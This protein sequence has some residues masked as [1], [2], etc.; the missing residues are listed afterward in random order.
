VALQAAQASGDG[1]RAAFLT[2]D[3]TLYLWQLTPLALMGRLVV[4]GP[5]RL[6]RWSA[7][8]PVTFDD[9]GELLVIASLDGHVRGWTTAPVAQVL[10]VV[11]TPPG[12][13]RETRP[14]TLRV[15]STLG[16]NLMEWW[17]VSPVQDVALAHGLP[18]LATATG[19]WLH[20]WNVTTGLALDS[21]RYL[22]DSG[23]APLF[24]SLAFGPA[25][26]TLL[27]ATLDGRV[28]SYSRRPLKV[29]WTRSYLRSSTDDFVTTRD[30]GSF[31]LA[32]LDSLVVGSVQTG[33]ER[34]RMPLRWPSAITA[35]TAGDLVAL[36]HAG[37]ILVLNA[38]TC[39]TLS[40]DRSYNSLPIGVWSSLSCESVYVVS[41]AGDVRAVPL[42]PDRRGCFRSAPSVPA[43]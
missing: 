39:E 19:D 12:T 32:T 14:A 8:P 35:A 37:G 5:A 2:E 16:M 9:S 27:A 30:G 34:C 20:L 18:V 13:L 10:N 25:T 22:P 36:A 29:N 33:E 23:E 42:P 3:G 40:V 41:R 43:P 6:P 1:R 11:P 7:A 28:I 17:G 38:T 31:V 24:H 15:D 26:N 21:I 4:P